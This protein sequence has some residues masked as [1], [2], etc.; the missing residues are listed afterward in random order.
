[1]GEGWGRLDLFGCCGYFGRAAATGE[2]V[3]AEWTAGGCKLGGGKAVEY[4][5]VW[6]S[7][8]K[9]QAATLVRLY[10][11]INGIMVQWYCGSMV[12]WYYGSM[13]QWYYVVLCS[14]VLCCCS[15]TS[16]TVARCQLSLLLQVYRLPACRTTLSRPGCRIQAAPTSNASTRPSGNMTLNPKQV[17]AKMRQG[18]PKR[19]RA[20]QNA[21]GRSKKAVPKA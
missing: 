4:G 21:S 13:V 8:G 9:G 15:P 20:L 3:A 16:K 10:H 12:Q 11:D 14:V 17:S 6:E 5:K 2:D 7:M 1:M 19:V 18:A